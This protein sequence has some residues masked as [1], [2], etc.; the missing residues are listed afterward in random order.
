MAA[1]SVQAV[2][3]ELDLM[4][5]APPSPAERQAACRSLVRYE[6]RGGGNDSLSASEDW[7]RLYIALRRC[8]GEK[9]RVTVEMLR[10]WNTKVS[11]TAAIKRKCWIVP[12]AGLQ[13]LGREPSDLQQWV[14]DPSSLTD[15]PAN[16][17]GDDVLI[18][19]DGYDRSKLPIP[20]ILHLEVGVRWSAERPSQSPQQQQLQQQ[21]ASGGAQMLEP[22]PLPSS[23][24]AEICRPLPRTPHARAASWESVGHTPP[25]D[26]RVGMSPRESPPLQDIVS[27]T[28][29]AVN[30]G[31]W[32]SPDRSSPNIVE[33]WLRI[34]TVHI[35]RKKEPATEAEYGYIKFLTKELY[36][37]DSF[38]VL[39]KLV[40]HFQKLD[41]PQVSL[42]SP[43]CQS[44]MDLARVP[45]SASQ[46]EEVAEDPLH[47]HVH[48]GC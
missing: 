45:L 42:V 6:S 8:G 35:S 17:G 41:S 3:H 18:V 20:G 14:L 48:A 44:L 29:A 32:V 21:S 9:A 34:F 5:R 30:E 37:A 11:Q 23:E 4:E 46:G 16:I 2:K 28:L 47:V 43:L 7:V 27:N 39:D 19:D 10:H 40:P 22:I 1:Y 25:A 15:L 33:F 13:A 31:R 38:C 24:Q 36:Q 12:R 26:A